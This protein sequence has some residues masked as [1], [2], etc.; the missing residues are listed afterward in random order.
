MRARDKRTDVPKRLE[1]D[2][3]SIEKNDYMSNS[4]FDDFLEM[5]EK[6]ELTATKRDELNKVIDDLKSLHASP[7]EDTRRDA[8]MDDGNDLSVN[9]E[10]SCADENE[11]NNIID[12]LSPVQPLA[13]SDGDDTC[14]QT[15]VPICISI[16]DLAHESGCANFG[17]E[18]NA[19]VHTSA[20]PENIHTTIGSR[21]CDILNSSDRID[22][23]LQNIKTCMGYQ[24]LH[25]LS[26]G[27][28]HLEC[29]YYC[30]H[31]GN[32][33]IDPVFVN[34]MP[35]RYTCA[36]KKKNKFSLSNKRF[37]TEF[38]KRVSDISTGISYC[39]VQS[40]HV[41][42]RIS[43]VN[44][45][46][47]LKLGLLYLCKVQRIWKEILRVEIYKYM[48]VHKGLKWFVF[49]DVCDSHYLI[50]DPSVSCLCEKSTT[51]LSFCLDI[52]DP[53]PA[54][55]EME[56]KCR[57]WVLS[58]VQE[59]ELLSLREYVMRD[60][61]ITLNMPS[62]KYCKSRYRQT[63]RL[64]YVFLRNITSAIQ[65]LW[66]ARYWHTIQDRRDETSDLLY[67]IC[68]TVCVTKNMFIDKFCN[69]C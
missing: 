11:V 65:I 60:V 63:S 7:H 39:I 59:D 22:M 67:N 41:R 17:N 35:L 46:N 44:I 18:V 5:L 12:N 24:M 51:R 45:S 58:G 32:R 14:A 28:K 16:E 1:M 53:Y 30:M 66:S 56:N 23:L 33:N 13:A 68:H 29:D 3:D 10:L 4:S 34:C 54:S 8:A 36:Y 43:D 9:K 20:S 50:T 2:T 61:C 38:G 57:K 31:N 52:P 69:V 42:E 64:S 15:Y 19:K 25:I 6:E 26:S 27:M 47:M 48:N 62:R 40:I 55:C 21:Q 37:L 49:D